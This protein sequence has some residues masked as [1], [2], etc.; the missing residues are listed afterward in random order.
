MLPN[1]RHF[2]ACAGAGAA[3]WA[4]S[5]PTWAAQTPTFGGHAFGSYWRISVAAGERGERLRARIE[6]VIGS[7][8][9]AMSPYRADSEISRFNAARS[10][11]WMAVTPATQS[12]VAAALS[13]A[14][15]C[16]GAFDPTVGPLVG[17]Y[18]FGP[19][20]GR[21]SGDHRQLAVGAGAIRKHDAHLSLDLCGIA[22]GHALDGI[23]AA[24]DGAGLGSF[25][26]ELGGEV[27][28]RGRHPSGRPW[29]VAIEDPR[30]DATGLVHL[31][32]LDGQAIATSG[33]KVNGYEVGGRR[34]GHIV[35]PL[36]GSAVG[37]DLQSVSVMADRALLADGLATGMMAMGQERATAFARSQGLD[38]LLLVRDGMHLKSVVTGGFAARLLT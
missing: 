5:A 3:S 34:Y 18:G 15:R 24:L 20:T 14:Q 28:A 8:D 36:T 22:K 27:F 32:A 17:R 35:D 9:R 25:L 37:T 19:I 33:N 29:Q 12:V 30:A 10:T 7:V 21:R 1:R 31:V 4:L 26:F 2:L 23:V 11:G 38:A 13:M 6:S 16:Q